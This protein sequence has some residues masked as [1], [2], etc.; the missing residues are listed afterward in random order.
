MGWQI[1]QHRDG[2]VFFL[3]FNHRQGRPTDNLNLRRALQLALDMDEM[4]YKVTK[5]P[6]YEPGVSLFPG[7]LMGEE[8]LLRQEYPPKKSPSTRR[9]R[10]SICSKPCKSWASANRLLLCCWPATTPFRT[11]NPSGYNKP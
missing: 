4:V 8:R 6:G 10:N 9:W 3:E 5:L 11:C 2:T 1:R 7:W